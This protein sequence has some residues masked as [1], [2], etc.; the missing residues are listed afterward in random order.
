MKGDPVIDWNSIARRQF[1][2]HPR[3][4]AMMGS[5]ARETLS[6]SPVAADY[7]SDM[8]LLKLTT[9][10]LCGRTVSESPQVEMTVPASWWQHLKHATASWRDSSVSKKNSLGGFHRTILLK[11]VYASLSWLLRKHPVRYAKMTATIDFRQDV[12]YPE[13]DAPPN[14]GRPVIF[15]EMN[16]TPMWE[17]KTALWGTSLQSDPSRFMDSHEIMSQMQRDPEFHGENLRYPDSPGPYAV[18]QWLE[19]HGVNVD[20]FV[21]RQAP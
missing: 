21:K 4:Y 10:V 3:Q 19:R 20:Q 14:G 12:L 6:A 15:E 18:L 2:L 7:L 13:I 5:Y 16:M 11:P 8:L 9:A 17:P 1:T